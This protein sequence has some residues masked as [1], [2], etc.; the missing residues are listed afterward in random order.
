[1]SVSKK[2]FDFTAKQI[3][4]SM[5]GKNEED[6]RSEA[7]SI[8]RHHIMLSMGAGFIP[9][10]LVD[11][12]AVTAIQLDMIK[13]L[14]RVYGVKYS[15]T[16]GKA[17]VSALTSSSMARIAA[18]GAIKVI[19]GIGTILGGV[20]VTVATGASTYA[21]GEVF[22]RHFESGGTILDFDTDSFKRAYKEKF[23]KGKKVAKEMKE[24]DEEL[25]QKANEEMV[26]TFESVVA[27]AEAEPVED[28]SEDLMDKSEIL[29]QLK[30]LG[31]LKDKGIISDKEFSTM[32][33]KLLED[34]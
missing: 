15:E 13:Q 17:I 12:L 4:D 18:R 9:L 32:K 20:A 3:K 8:I 31:E 26:S 33:K 16:Q 30:E 29:A 34:F 22:K 21:L 2:I 14:C 25:K 19:P 6:P 28:T 1:M 5:S 23:E 27:K 10:P 11:I 7:N 24:K